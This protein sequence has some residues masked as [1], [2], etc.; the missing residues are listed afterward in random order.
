MKKKENQLEK[1]NMRRLKE[2]EKRERQLLD[3]IEPD[4]EFY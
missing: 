3:E 2:I 1:D 4:I